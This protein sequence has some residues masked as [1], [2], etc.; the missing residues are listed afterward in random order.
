[1]TRKIKFRAWDEKYKYMNYK[2]SVG[3]DDLKD[4]NYTCHTMYVTPDKV[5]YKCEPHWMG[6]E[7][8]NGFQLMQFTGLYDKNGK[9]IYEGDILTT[10]I[11]GGGVVYWDEDCWML[12]NPENQKQS[13]CLST[14]PELEV[15]GNIYE[16][17]HLLP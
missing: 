8:D 15:I 3:N 17:P 5:D 13:D 16:H 6:F 12:G 1:M 9:E 14:F 7:V 2:V 4:E 10:S 11:F